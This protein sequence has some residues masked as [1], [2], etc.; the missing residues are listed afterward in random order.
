MHSCKAT[1]PGFPS[2][3]VPDARMQVMRL[4]REMARRVH[5]DYRTRLNGLQTKPEVVTKKHRQHRATSPSSRT[6][7]V[8]MRE[9]DR[10]KRALKP[11]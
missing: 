8:R 6:E 3:D 5:Y 7:E 10:A 9:M 2:P 11:P 4:K 1:V